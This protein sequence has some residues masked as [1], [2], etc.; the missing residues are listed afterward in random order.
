MEVPQLFATFVVKENILVAPSLL[1]MDPKRHQPLSQRRFRLRS[2]MSLITKDPKRFWYLKL[3]DFLL[4]GLE[5]EKWFLNSGCSRH[6]TGDESKFV[7]LTRR[8]LGYV[9]FGDNMKGKILDMVL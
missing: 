9:T 5:K 4:Y 3:L 7:F 2:Q 1:K 6:M 8:K